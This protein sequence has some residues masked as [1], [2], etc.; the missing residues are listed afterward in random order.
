MLPKHYKKYRKEETENG[1]VHKVIRLLKESNTYNEVMTVLCHEKRDKLNGDGL[2]SIINQT[3]HKIIS[4]INVNPFD[5]LFLDDFKIQDTIPYNE[6]TEPKNM[7]FVT[8]LRLL[9][10]TGVIRHVP[11]RNISLVYEKL[12]KI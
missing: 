3:T 2:S 8:F 6:I 4:A 9:V 11:L 1:C 7:V 5:V 10:E 12:S